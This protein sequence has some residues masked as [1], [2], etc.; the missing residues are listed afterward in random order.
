MIGFHHVML[1]GL[2]FGLS[3]RG[4]GLNMNNK[5][6]IDRKNVITKV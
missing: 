1:L 3:G 5:N 2:A 4:M 6:E